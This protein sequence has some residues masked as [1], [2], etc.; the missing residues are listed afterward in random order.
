MATHT[1][2]LRELALLGEWERYR[3]LIEAAC[4]AECPPAGGPSSRCC[5]RDARLERPKR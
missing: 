3:G 2:R 1:P 4:T 5:F